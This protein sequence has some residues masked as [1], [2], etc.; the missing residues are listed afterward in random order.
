MSKLRVFILLNMLL[1]AIKRYRNW[2]QFPMVARIATKSS[3]ND[4]H[5]SQVQSLLENNVES[6]QCCFSLPLWLLTL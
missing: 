6:Y 2:K 3:L 4:G 5:S 1:D